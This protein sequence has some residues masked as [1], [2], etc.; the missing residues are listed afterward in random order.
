MKHI[1]MMSEY[2]EDK[3]RQQSGPAAFRRSGEHGGWSVEVRKHATERQL[4]RDRRDGPKVQG[5]DRTSGRRGC[6]R[7]GESGG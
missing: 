2:L 1:K 4:A 6:D 7:A 3:P 5:R